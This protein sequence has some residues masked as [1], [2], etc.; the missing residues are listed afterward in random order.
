MKLLRSLGVFS[1]AS[2]QNFL[3]IGLREMY[4]FDIVE[5]S[6]W[7]EPLLFLTLNQNLSRQL[8]RLGMA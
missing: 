3:C 1:V 2:L 7:N 5:W 6:F 8:T 4:E